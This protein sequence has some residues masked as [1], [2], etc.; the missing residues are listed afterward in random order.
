M[1]QERRVWW[2]SLAI[3]GLLGGIWAL[4]S[5][6][7]SVPDE[8]A[9]AIRA[10]AVWHGELVG[11]E[12][13][14][15]GLT[16]VQVQDRVP[17]AYAQ[18]HAEP[19][20]YKGQP[21]V[22]ASC[23]PS[24]GTG[25]TATAV[26]SPAGWY[27]PLYYIAV[28]WPGRLLSPYRALYAMRLCSVAIGA[29]L[30]ASAMA[31]AFRLARSKFVVVGVALA[32]T[33]T[34]LFLIGSINPNG[35]EIAAGIA[36][37]VTVL[38][39]LTRRGPPSPRL[40]VRVT[41]VSACMLLARPLSPFFWAVI[42]LSVLAMAATRARLSVLLGDTQARIAAGGLAIVG[43]FSG[44]WFLATSGLAAVGLPQT[45]VAE[46]AGH[47]FRHIP[48]LLQQMVGV[49]GW[50][51]TPTPETL[52][53]VWIGAILVVGL[54]GLVVA[55]MRR[56]VVLLA[57]GVVVLAIPVV[58][59]ATGVHSYGYFWQGR[60]SL[61]LIAGL[62]VLA[63]WMVADS[64]R[65]GRP[66]RASMAVVI[67]VGVGV[68]QFIAHGTGFSRYV[69]GG[70]TGFVSYIHGGAWRP[71]VPVVVLL[72]GALVSFGVYGLWIALVGSFES[73]DSIGDP[74]DSEEPGLSVEPNGASERAL[75]SPR[76]L[77]GP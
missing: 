53:R 20:C 43:L 31:S 7:M 27:P 42:V 74:G 34:A 29:A 37:W 13:G 41:V 56:R 71:T 58:I 64:T 3:F 65:I 32:A 18:L 52:S 16:D 35:F 49:F 21:W 22:P 72:I 60:Y 24:V 5:P 45:T 50:L 59:E 25:T 67:G 2:V 1:G 38:D 48:T 14:G 68:E 17:D 66:L 15:D 70:P 55:S 19:A 12:V 33:P 6:L 39:L 46:A 75:G 44:V 57:V 4:S 26:F 28:G 8:P 10:V 9:H 76:P 54:V 61:P 62:P 63:S 40:I 69:R 30:L 51:D 77:T 11:H 47:S 23:A 36:T 73:T